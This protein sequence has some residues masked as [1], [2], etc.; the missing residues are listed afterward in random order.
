MSLYG[1]LIRARGTG[2]AAAGTK[3]GGVLILAAV[4]SAVAA[5]SISVTA[6]LG[7]VALVV[8]IVLITFFGVEPVGR[9]SSR[10]RPRSSPSHWPMK[11][12]ARLYAGITRRCYPPT[13]ELG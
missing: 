1:T 11:R 10:S 3:L 9:V 4:A 13:M 6:E 8:A 7:A 2:L 12:S 5:P